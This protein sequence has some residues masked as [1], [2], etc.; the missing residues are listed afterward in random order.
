MRIFRHLPPRRGDPQDAG[1][2]GALPAN[3]KILWVQALTG[4]AARVLRW[5]S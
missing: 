4:A 1:L 2:F 3:P 5:A